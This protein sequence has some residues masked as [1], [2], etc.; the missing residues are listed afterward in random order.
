MKA[1]ILSAMTLALALTSAGASAQSMDLAQ[2]F[3]EALSNDTVV[4]SARAQL[5]ATRERVPQAQAG[6]LP[7]VT[8][9]AVVN[10]QMVDTNVA[11]RR[12]F[13][14]Q[15][16][17]VNLTY[18]LYRLQN[19]ETLEQSKLQAAIAEAQ[20][21]QAQQDLAVRVSQAYFDV[22]ASQDTLATIRA[23][24]RAITEQLASARRN[25]EVGTATIT[26][27][28]E[29]Q[30]RFDLTQAQEFVAINDLAVKR[31]NLTQLVGKPSTRLQVL[32]KGLT[33]APPS[34]ASES[35]WTENARQSSLLVQQSKVGVEVARR[36]INKQRHASRPTVDLVSSLGHARS[37]AAN[38]IGINS[39]SALLGVQVAVP[40][41]TGGAI[42]ARVREAASLRDKAETDL[43]NVRRQ[44]EQ[45]A[46]QS[47]LGVNSGLAQVSALEAAEKSS[48]LAL[49]SNLLGYQVGVRI[50][51]DVLNAQQQLFNT[52][53]DLAKARYDVLL[54][55]LRLKFTS[56]ALS[57][58][59]LQALSSLL[60]IPATDP[61]EPPPAP[62]SA[63]PT[64][65]PV[66]PRGPMGRVGG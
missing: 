45:S 56:A 64:V 18:P 26:D 32:R 11:P 52:Q 13:T 17:S 66:A 1:P 25:F 55:G 42:D 10:R 22:L 37:A 4:A 40:L 2:A 21:A 14:G 16:Y 62:P 43:E 6:L 46:R 5:A 61:T 23:Q 36:E 35:A 24:K 38:F 3:R 39:T 44:V 65:T 9:S 27:Q 58:A 57:E 47:F 41:Y 63:N 19:I 12:D 49:D 59:D 51:I 31:A 33:L 53:R 48:Q 60:E 34:P 30:A 8:G 50:N 29:A 20:L 15:N 7:S 28:Q 54:N